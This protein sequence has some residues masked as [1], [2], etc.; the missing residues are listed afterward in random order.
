MKRSISILSLLLTFVAST[1]F[2]NPIAF[3]PYVQNMTDDQATVFWT[4]YKTSVDIPYEKGTG[5]KRLYDQHEITFSRLEADTEYHYD[6][7]KDGI[8]FGKGSFRT[9]KEGIAPFKFVVYGDT[10]FDHKIHR[11]IVELSEKEDP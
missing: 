4:T 7:L 11:K 3:G 8:D 1:S 2:A 10:R 9:S 5:T 6:V